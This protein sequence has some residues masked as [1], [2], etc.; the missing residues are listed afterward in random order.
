MY[1][2]VCC[3]IKLHYGGTLIY[4]MYEIVRL[5]RVLPWNTNGSSVTNALSHTPYFC[6]HVND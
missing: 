4:K 2:H 5:I 3:Y 1:L 6:V